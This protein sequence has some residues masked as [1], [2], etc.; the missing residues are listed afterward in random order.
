MARAAG[1]LDGLTHRFKHNLRCERERSD[2]RPRRNRAVMQTK[3]SASCYVIGKHP[4]DFVHLKNGR[5]WSVARGQSP[6]V[7]VIVGK[8]KRILDPILSVNVGGSQRK[9]PHRKR[10]CR[11]TSLAAR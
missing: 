1:T 11:S 6:A 3:E 4:L 7:F 8:S 5:P 10:E 9:T 2:D